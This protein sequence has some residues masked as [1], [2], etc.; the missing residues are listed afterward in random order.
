MSTE[1]PVVPQARPHSRPVP[2]RKLPGSRIADRLGR[3]PQDILRMLDAL[4]AT[5]SAQPVGG[6]V[7][8]P[9]WSRQRHLI[10]VT[11]RRSGERV[12][13]P[14]WAAS[15]GAV[16][17]VRTQRASGKVKRVRNNG[18][19]LIAPCTT[20]GVPL[21]APVDGRASLLAPEQEHV[22]ERALRRKY[23]VVRAFC[24]TV[25]DLLR[26]DMCYL[27]VTIDTPATG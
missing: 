13:T 23:G 25:Q 4:P 14:V 10:M 9:D 21:A 16:L 22:A 2:G 15:D 27:A 26:V 7:T 5:A 24:A 17:Y 8:G 1:R 20:R 19:V 12:A 3:P 11:L 6:T 18:S